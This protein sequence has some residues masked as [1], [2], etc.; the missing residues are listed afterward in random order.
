MTDT[1]HR[2]T[3]PT[4]D[5]GGGEGVCPYCGED[6]P[7]RVAP[8]A[9]RRTRPTITV[10]L[11]TESLARL[12]AMATETCQTR[13]RAVEQIMRDHFHAPKPRRSGG[14]HSR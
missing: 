2:R 8:T 1:T 11:S 3:R 9:H 10:T 4:C 6:V 14:E 7:S 5:H 12:D 13:S